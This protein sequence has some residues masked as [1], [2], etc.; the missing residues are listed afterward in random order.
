MGSVGDFWQV[1]LLYHSKRLSLPGNADM[2][3]IREHPVNHNCNITLRVSSQDIFC[4]PFTCEQKKV[5]RPGDHKYGSEIYC[6]GFRPFI[7]KWQ[8]S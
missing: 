5:H 2:E 3:V 8:P 7:L 4:D 1:S 6:C